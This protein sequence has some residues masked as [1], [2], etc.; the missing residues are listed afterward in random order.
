MAENGCLEQ[1]LLYGI[2][3]NSTIFLKKFTC[4]DGTRAIAIKLFYP[5]SFLNKETGSSD[6]IESKREVVLP[7]FDAYDLAETI[8]KLIP[9][10]SRVEK[11]TENF[12]GQFTIPF[13]VVYPLDEQKNG[14]RAKETTW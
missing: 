2:N 1:Q 8:L 7:A 4:K 11:K 5:E 13:K 14:R 9:N 3:R 10:Q 6:L 12:F